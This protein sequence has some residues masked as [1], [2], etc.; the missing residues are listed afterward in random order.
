[1]S[2]KPAERPA[3]RDQQDWAQAIAITLAASAVLVAAVTWVTVGRAAEARDE[4]RRAVLQTVQTELV[5]VGALAQ[6][7]SE[8]SN[9]AGYLAAH[10]RAGALA[11]LGGSLARTGDVV[12]ANA[13][14][15]EADTTAAAAEA[16]APLGFD[17]NYL[18]DGRY[19][20]DGRQRSLIRTQDSNALSTDA[21]DEVAHEADAL[22]AD[23]GRLAMLVVVV[24][25]VILLLTM[26]RI[27]SGDNRLGLLVSAWFLLAGVV[28]TGSLIQ[29][30]P[31]GA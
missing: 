23:A 19:D 14:A 16:S 17:R 21:P 9:A 26:A 25:G 29:W 31:A 8:S 24:V 10:A 18:A 27:V 13:L 5:R 2:D 3:R 20:T 6:A 30:G 12:G 22:H 1:M 15:D 7:H 4:D 28:V 11:S